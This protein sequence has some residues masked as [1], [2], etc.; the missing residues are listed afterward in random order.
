ML[1]DYHTHTP[2]CLH[3]EGHPKEYAQQALASGLTEMGISDHNPMPEFFDD[4]RMLLSDWPRYLELVDEA[5]VL[6]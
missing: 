6:D 4:W 2:L 3:A 1:A 5:R